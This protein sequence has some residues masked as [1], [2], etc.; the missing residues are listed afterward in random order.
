MRR[1]T[2]SSTRSTAPTAHSSSSPAKKLGLLYLP[3]T[4]GCNFI[5]TV[6]QK[7]R[8][9]QGGTVKA[10]ERFAGGGIKTPDRLYGSLKAVDPATGEIKAA[11]RL[12]YPNYSGALATAGNLIFLGHPD[13][14]FSA[15]DAR[16]LQELWSFNAGTGINAPA[17]TYA[18][19]GTQYV[20]VLVGSKQPTAVMPNAPELK[21]TSTAS[22]L[23]VF[24]L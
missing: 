2:A 20:A 13:G 10:R 4:E 16:T 22:M 11:L 8:D 18:V 17:V 7:D 9:D 21:Y 1:A 6:E 5:E 14:T 23:Y 19:N 15:Y 12:T 24:S 3:S